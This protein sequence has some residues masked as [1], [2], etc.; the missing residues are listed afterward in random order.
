MR[1]RGGYVRAARGWAGVRACGRTAGIE[2]G[3]G[4]ERGDVLVRE[5]EMRTVMVERMGDE[6]VLYVHGERLHWGRCRRHRGSLPASLTSLL[7]PTLFYLPTCLCASLPVVQQTSPNQTHMGRVTDD[8]KRLNG[9]TTQRPTNNH[10]THNTDKNKKGQPTN[11]NRTLNMGSSD[12]SSSFLPS[13][14]SP[15]THL[16]C[17]RDQAV[18]GGP[19][20]RR[21]R[22]PRPHLARRLLGRVSQH[23]PSAREVLRLQ[24]WSG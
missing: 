2:G 1:V 19:P 10:L 12:P 20:L 23:L 14:P 5:V 13:T 22:R 6:N 4:D 21:H 16:D 24:L 18:N 7:P 8:V 17:R 11:N 3:G 15:L 9:K